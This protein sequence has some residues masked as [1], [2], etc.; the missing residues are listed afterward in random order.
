MKSA[1]NDVAKLCTWWAIH[2]VFR[3]T[4]NF[5]FPLHVYCL[6]LTY[7]RWSEWC[8]VKFCVDEVSWNFCGQKMRQ[9]DYTEQT[10]KLM[11]KLESSVAHCSQIRTD[12]ELRHFTRHSLSVLWNV[13]WNLCVSWASLLYFTWFVPDAKCVL[14]KRICV[15]VCPLPHAHST[16]RT[17]M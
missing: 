9:F 4:S 10:G 2:S 1:L 15:S 5:H 3:M 12:M 16:A 6:L 8:I 14:V 7:V 11:L 13:L 17:R